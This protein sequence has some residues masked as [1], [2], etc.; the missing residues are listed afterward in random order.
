MAKRR[1]NCGLSL[2]EANVKDA[3]LKKHIN[4]GEISNSEQALTKKPGEVDSPGSLNLLNF[5]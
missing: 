5:V 3:P 2:Y 4:P 1:V